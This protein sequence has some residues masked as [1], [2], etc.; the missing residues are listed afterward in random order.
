MIERAVLDSVVEKWRGAKYTNLGG[1]GDG[2]WEEVRG[3][4]YEKTQ[5]PVAMCFERGEEI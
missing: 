2:S 4:Q 1:G 3:V 5:L